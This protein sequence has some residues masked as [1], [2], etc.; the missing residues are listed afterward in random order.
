[1]NKLQEMFKTSELLSAYA[2]PQNENL[3]QKHKLIIS[4]MQFANKLK[5]YLTTEQVNELIQ[6]LIS[7]GKLVDIGSDK[8]ASKYSFNQLLNEYTNQL[9]KKSKHIILLNLIE[10]R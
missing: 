8:Y 1:M 4:S 7:D 2:I 3:S 9:I 10:Q 6:N 5:D